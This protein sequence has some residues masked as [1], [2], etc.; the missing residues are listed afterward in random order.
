[1]YN[2]FLSFVFIN[3]I[4]QRMTPFWSDFFVCNKSEY[5]NYAN[6]NVIIYVRWIFFDDCI[7]CGSSHRGWG[8]FRG[9]D[10]AAP[11][12]YCRVDVPG[13]QLSWLLEMSHIWSWWL[14]TNSN[15]VKG[16]SQVVRIDGIPPCAAI[17]LGNLLMWLNNKESPIRL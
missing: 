2:I 12:E 4:P 17:E 3:L 15:D 11:S 16:I 7:N 1:M 10:G 9:I 8:E 5:S 13:S 14:C 6:H